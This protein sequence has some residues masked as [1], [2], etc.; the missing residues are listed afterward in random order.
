MFVSITAAMA[1]TQG[2]QL[3]N[4]RQVVFSTQMPSVDAQA[5][6]QTIRI[7]LFMY[8]NNALDMF[9]LLLL[10]LVAVLNFVS[11]T[12]SSGVIWLIFFIALAGIHAFFWHVFVQDMQHSSS[13]IIEWV[14][15]RPHFK[16]RRVVFSFFYLL[17]GV[18]FLVFPVFQPWD[19]FV[20]PFVRWFAYTVDGELVWRGIFAS[21]ALG[22]F[23][24]LL[25]P[26][27]LH[28]AYILYVAVSG[29]IHATFMLIAN[30]I[31]RVQ[32]LPNGNSEHLYGD[33]LGWYVIAAFS[34]IN[35]S[36]TG[37]LS[38]KPSTLNSAPL[39]MVLQYQTSSLPS[40]STVDTL[41]LDVNNGSLAKHPS[42]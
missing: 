29:F 38:A 6:A 15:T 36:G 11:H 2:W 33:I 1:L 3:W 5:S 8:P 39:T 24:C 20:A 26:F 30:L 21:Y 7:P 13:Q 41:V 22:F 31:S 14:A 17:W 23:Y 25:D 37:V 42:S 16:L 34:A 28:V 18:G 35:L 12:P 19:G 4:C 40:P 32:G 10:M 27:H 9:E